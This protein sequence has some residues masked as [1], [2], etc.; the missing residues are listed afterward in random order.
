MKEGYYKEY[1]QDWWEDE[2]S[3]TG[4]TGSGWGEEK[5]FEMVEYLE[6]DKYGNP[7]K[8][9]FEY[10]GP[11]FLGFQHAAYNLQASLLSEFVS[12]AKKYHGKT[13]DEVYEIEPD[14]KK[15]NDAIDVLEKQFE[16]KKY[17][18]K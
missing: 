15:L 7:T 14:F 16:I 13:F 18:K 2:E 5:G 1:H 12:Y 10:E 6:I 3:K 17:L 11:I 9:L 4:W 8:A